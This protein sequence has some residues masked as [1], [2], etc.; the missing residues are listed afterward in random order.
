[1]I[2]DASITSLLPKP[3]KTVKMASIPNAFRL[4]QTQCLRLNYV[5]RK[6]EKLKDSQKATVI[7]HKI[8]LKNE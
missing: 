1:M 6:K 3:G 8:C 4:A 7:N 2:G 5:L